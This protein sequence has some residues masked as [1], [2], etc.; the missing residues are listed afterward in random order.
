MT[1]TT[2][3]R[4]QSTPELPPRGRTSTAP[5]CVKLTQKQKFGHS[6]TGAPLGF[7]QSP[8]FSIMSRDSNSSNGLF[9]GSAVSLTAAGPGSYPGID[10]STLLE[11]GPS[12]T[13]T[14][15]LNRRLRDCRPLTGP[16]ATLSLH[17]ADRLLLEQGPES[18]ELGSLGC[19]EAAKA[20]PN[21]GS[22]VFN[23][24]TGRF[25]PTRVLGSGME[26]L[27]GDHEE[28]KYG[29]TIPSKAGLDGSLQMDDER[30]KKR[31]AREELLA[32][33]AAFK[34][35]ARVKEE[36]KA[37]A[38]E[39]EGAR[40]DSANGRVSPTFG[41]GGQ[42]AATP[43]VMPFDGT[44]DWDKTV[45]AQSKSGAQPPPPAQ[46]E[47]FRGWKHELQPLAFVTGGYEGGGVRPWTNSVLNNSH[48]GS[49]GSVRFSPVEGGM[50][51]G[52]EGMEER[53]FTAGGV[54]EGS[55]GGTG[56]TVRFKKKR[57]MLYPWMKEMY[58]ETVSREEV[59]QVSD[60]KGLDTFKPPNT[61]SMRFY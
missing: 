32:K 19:F 45:V 26:K 31:R 56:E 5:A 17:G 28:K 15:T 25:P 13:R 60:V 36:A 50:G 44:I 59:K 54:D 53:G 57:Q 22:A 61:K 8:C 21:F 41:G 49:A 27:Q 10:K 34:E 1:K 48:G 47:S 39:R 43:V 18:Y 52:E 37:A 24:Q 2:M 6:F 55:V 23:S 12:K 33:T 14:K 58:K 16:Q 4:S 38:R 9:L 35:A 30:A 29:R 3:L 51:M 40:A 42:R 20:L 11:P 7:N 46:F